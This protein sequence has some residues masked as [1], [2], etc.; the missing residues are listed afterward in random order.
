MDQTFCKVSIH[1]KEYRYPLGT[2]YREIAKA[3]AGQ[4]DTPIVLV[5]L[6]GYFLQEL[7]KPLSRDCRLDFVTTS[8]AIG[9]AAYTRSATLL[10][11]KAVHDL[12]EGEEAVQ[13]R[14][15]FSLCQGLYCT[16][17]GNKKPDQ[18]FLDALESRMRQL[19]EEGCPIQ[20]R[21]VHTEEAIRLFNQYGMRDKEELFRYRRVSRVNL[22]RIHGYEDYFY[23]YMVPDTSYL[24]QF[25]LHLYDEGFVLQLP[26]PKEPSKTP[27]F[28]P[29][30]KLFQVLKQ[31]T[32]WGDLQGI[33]T[34]GDLN[35]LITR[36]DVA[37]A[38]L[39]QESYQEQRIHAIAARIAERPQVKFVLI[40]GPSSSG[41]TTFSQRLSIALQVA[42][43]RPHTISV[44]NY[45]VNREDTP[46]DA[47]GNYNF[48]CLEALD[49]EGFNRDMGDLLKGRR[50]QLPIFDFEMGKRKD[51]G[52]P[53]SMGERD[54]L[55]IEGIHCLNP[56]LTRNLAQENQFRI[57]INCLT[58]LNIDEHNRIPSTDGRIFRRIVRDARTRGLS[59]RDTIRMWPS[60]R[61]GEEENIFPFQEEA[62]VMF[63]SNLVYEL[64]V[65]KP[66]VEPLLFRIQRDQAEYA[67]AKRLLKFLDY[68]LTI[69]SHY[70]PTD[71]LLR[72]FIG[73]GNFRL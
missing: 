18:A 27:P 51:Q 8:D 47:Q 70:V 56:R 24:T 49:V 48:E 22:Y 42:G 57:Y 15:H 52:I 64:A 63:N 35:T 1:E 16:L 54:I 4:Y 33:R 40:A 38:V 30:P 46:L 23:G 3:H 61:R 2:P 6:D 20:K 53:L 68:F 21:S 10:L 19:V 43:L 25:S 59:A 17:D 71:S 39:I 14:V 45:F 7:G 9:H 67:E 72:E 44:D 58:Q 28:V 65:L 5:L 36:K 73:G 55:V 11:C 41:K 32:R 62:D 31:A 34:V 50:V 66:Y 60:V 69:D 12:L 13:V 29:Q 37:Q 26:T